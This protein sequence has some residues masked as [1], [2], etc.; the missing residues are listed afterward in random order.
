MKWTIYKRP[1][2]YCV[3]APTFKD[4]KKLIKYVGSLDACKRRVIN[5]LGRDTQNNK[6]QVEEIKWIINT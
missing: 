6:Y 5:N 4:D 2:D 1:D 3:Y